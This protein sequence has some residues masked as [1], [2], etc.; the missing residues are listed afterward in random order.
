MARQKQEKTDPRTSSPSC[1]FFKTLFSCPFK[2]PRPVQRDQPAHSILSTHVIQHPFF[3]RCIL[4]KVILPN[5]HLL[6]SSIFFR[7]RLCLLDCNLE[8]LADRQSLPST[9]NLKSATCSSRYILS[10]LASCE[11]LFTRHTHNLA[12]CPPFGRMMR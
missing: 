9:P 1:S 6:P 2:V 8:L 4:S 12:P 10:I 11:H 5:A 3:H 7:S